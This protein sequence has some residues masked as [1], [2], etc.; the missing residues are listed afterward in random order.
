MG[1]ASIQLF[2]FLSLKYCYFRF[3][4]N[5][6]I[7]ECLNGHT[8]SKSVKESL[9]GRFIYCVNFIIQLQ[10]W[11]S[12]KAQYI[13]SIYSSVWNTQ[14]LQPMFSN[15]PLLFLVFSFWYKNS[16]PVVE[17]FHS[18]FSICSS[19]AFLYMVPGFF[20]VCSLL[21]ATIRQQKF[22]LPTKGEVHI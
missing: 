15:L 8:A 9:T 22:Q 19:P 10:C 20:F 6:L 12:K 3:L 11:D 13:Y 21:L 4:Q 16:T 7:W 1:V 5:F 14:K 18:S 2:L 17:E